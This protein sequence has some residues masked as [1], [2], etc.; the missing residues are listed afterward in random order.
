MKCFKCGKEGH[1]RSECFNNTKR[2]YDCNEMVTDIKS[3]RT[4]C[5]KSKREKSIIRQSNNNV[6]NGSDFYFLIDVSGS[7]AGNRLQ[8]AKNCALSL[9]DCMNESDRLPSLHS[10]LMHF[11]NLNRDL[12]DKLSGSENYLI[13]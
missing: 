9:I 11:L 10:I 4:V 3:H 12:L 13:S 8:S 7:M 2:C 1:K 6:R 5:A